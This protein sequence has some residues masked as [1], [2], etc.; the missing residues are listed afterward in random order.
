[1]SYSGFASNMTSYIAYTFSGFT[2]FTLGAG[3]KIG[4]FADGVSGGNSGDWIKLE[5]ASNPDSNTEVYILD[6]SPV[7]GGSST[8]N[9]DL[10]FSIT[11][12]AI[13]DQQVKVWF[14][15]DNNVQDAIED[16]QVK[17]WFYPD[18]NVQAKDQQVKVWFYPNN[19]VNPPETA[20]KWWLGMRGKKRYGKGHIRRMRI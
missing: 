13:E 11:Y 19:N 6:N 18:N 10:K 16:Q 2:N 3:E 14:Y 15:P 12:T 20:W 9:P 7:D 8:S 1:L 17:V 5:E 4:I